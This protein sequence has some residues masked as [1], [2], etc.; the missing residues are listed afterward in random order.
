MDEPT[1][2]RIAITIHKIPEKGFCG[3]VVLRQ[4]E[5]KTWRG[6]CSRCG[7]AF[8]MPHDPSFTHQVLALRN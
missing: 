3:V 1:S 8:E 6:V 2:S 5:D 7:A 4:G